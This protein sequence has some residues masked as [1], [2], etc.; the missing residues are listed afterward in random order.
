VVAGAIDWNICPLVLGMT[1]GSIALGP[2]GFIARGHRPSA[3]EPLVPIILGILICYVT[4]N[5]YYTV[6]YIEVA[7]YSLKEAKFNCHE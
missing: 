5:N 7:A 6:S 1:N 2:Q 4:K 3:I